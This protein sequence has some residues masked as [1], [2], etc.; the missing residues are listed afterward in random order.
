[1]AERNLNFDEIVDRKNTG[2]LKYDFAVRRGKPEDVLPLWVADMD[3]KVSSYIED[4]LMERVRHGIFGYSESDEVYFEAVAGWME[5]H[6]NWKI[7][8]EWMI[9]TPGVVFALAMAV[10]AYTEPGDAV[11]IQQP[12]YYPFS[13]VI[14]DNGRKIVSNDLVFTGQGT[15]E[16]DF[17]DFEAQIIQHHVKLFLLCSPHNPVGRVWT[18]EELTRVGE[19]CLKHHVIVV[20]DEI[21]HDFIF[22]GRHEVFASLGEAFRENCVVCTSASKTFNLACMLVS[23]IF[24]PNA[25]LRRRFQKQVDATGI[26]QLNALG[27]IATQTAYTQGEE[28]YQAAMQYI[29]ANHRFVEDY[30]NKNMPGVK[31]IHAQGTYLVWLDFGGTG[32]D[33]E[34]LDHRIIYDAKLWLDSGK[35]FGKSGEGF[36]R[37]NV[38]CPRKVLETAL[39]R[40]RNIL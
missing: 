1:M 40:L 5:K 11:L 37:I 33:A 20:S 12:V 21:H 2:C 22:E 31:V 4:A 24:I 26:S 30:V 17:D 3:F 27:L 15:Y 6:K 25:D 28:W 10:K 32:I 8:P 7:R 9:K 16:I 14:R 34:E 23:N 13:E 19:I 35:I 18:R 39:E 38:A 36:Q 29:G